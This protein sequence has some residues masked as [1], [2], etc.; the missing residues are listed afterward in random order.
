MLP[1]GRLSLGRLSQIINWGDG[2][3]EHRH[4]SSRPGAHAG[5]CGRRRAS[6]SLGLG[7]GHAA[8]AKGVGRVDV[9][10]GA[11][12]MVCGKRPIHTVGARCFSFAASPMACSRHETVG[13][14]SARWL[15]GRMLGH[16]A[17]YEVPP[18]AASAG[19]HLGIA[20]ALWVASL[21]QAGLGGNGG[22]RGQ[23]GATPMGRGGGEGGC[24]RTR[25]N[26]QTGTQPQQ[27]VPA[28]RCI[29]CL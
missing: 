4:G 22:C 26:K 18:E 8:S 7:S 21:P 10:M 2:R 16:W 3:E 12:G 15:G 24:Q 25:G 20:A 14:L 17:A 11:S 1:C 27:S 23:V 29:Q 9:G 19:L 28:R 13:D 5:P 6:P